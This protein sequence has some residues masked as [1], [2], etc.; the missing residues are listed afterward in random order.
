[1]NATNRSVGT[2]ATDA[3][4]VSVGRPDVRPRFMPWVM[5][6]LVVLGLLVAAATTALI[7]DQRQR[8]LS[9]ADR[10][11]RRLSLTL[12][13]EAERGLEAVDVVQNALLDRLRA[14][15]LRTPDNLRS[16]MSGLQAHEE[17]RGRQRTLSQLDA[18]TAIDADG[19]LINFSRSWPVPT[20]NVADRDYFKAL[21]ADPN[22]TSFV[23]EPVRNR[24]SGTWTIYLARRVNGDNDMFLGLILGAVQITYF[25]QLYQ[26]VAI[27]PENAISLYRTDGVLLARHPHQDSQ[28]GRS[29]GSGLLFPR[30]GTIDPNGFVRQHIS[31]VDGRQRMIGVYPLRH[32]PLAVTASDT[33]S[34]ILANW[35]AQTAVLLVAA[36]AIECVIVVVGGLTLRQFSGQ[37]VLLEAHAARTAAEAAQRAAEAELDRARERER[38]DRELATQ[39]SR[40][41]AALGNMSQALCMFDASDRLTVANTR[42]TEMLRIAGIDITPGITLDGLAASM[43]TDAGPFSADVAALHQTI[44]TFIAAGQRA[45]EV[46][47][48]SNGRTLALNFAPI[49]EAGWLVTLEDITRRQLAEA[50]I[51]HMA[52]HDSLT[53]LPNRVRLHEKLEEAVARSQRGEPSA[54]LFLDL[55]HFKAVNDTLGHPVGDALL[56]AV[57]LRLGCETRETDTIARLGGDEFAIVQFNA[58][59]PQAATTLASRLIAAVSAPFELDGHQVVIGTSV[60]IAMIPQDGS[61]PDQLLKNA[62]MALYQAKGDGRGRYRFFAP[63][64]DAQMQARRSLETDLRRALAQQEFK[65]FY[66]PLMNLKTRTVVG[67]EALLRWS[68]PQRGLVAPADFV[69]L[70]EEI[71]LIIPLGQWVLRQ[72][73]A[74]AAT[75]SGT[76]RVAVNLSPVQFGSRSLVADVAA[77]LQDSGLQPS[78]LELEI[79][80]T[81]M[82]D[83]TDAVL[84]VLHQLRDLGVDI[85]MDDFGPAFHR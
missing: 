79:T 48:L 17:L 16:L 59:Q 6:A 75:W 63:E 53:G 22:R 74:D 23:G 61:D 30:E 32:Y 47:T 65:L 36:A 41:S 57:T 51:A 28:I 52:H 20:V 10:D 42:M 8:A 31:P 14:A 7:V 56:Q 5:T 78:R 49:V 66:Q 83:D 12:A 60:G 19:N 24:G 46:V 73:C 38:A 39:N 67:F 9:S 4:P 76:Q 29:Y 77:A 1:M 3:G 35:R 44:K 15:G 37:R 85:A 70:A 54:V 72:A 13:A 26:A 71:G 84:A 40:F 45:A 80:E 64:M 2:P 58:E 18:I 82:L 33:T 11:L 50:R 81:V 68:H 62:D 21:K 27:G 55:D 43:L 25:E 34:A 69:P